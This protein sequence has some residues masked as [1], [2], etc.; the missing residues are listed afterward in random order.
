MDLTKYCNYCSLVQS[1]LVIT[2]AGILANGGQFSFIHSQLLNIIILKSN[3][4]SLLNQLG[5]ICQYSEC[6]VKYT[7]SRAGSILK[8][9]APAARA[10]QRINSSNIALPGRTILEL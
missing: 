3:S 1:S 10:I 4:P 2:P 8:N 7:S 6:T 5:N 9:I